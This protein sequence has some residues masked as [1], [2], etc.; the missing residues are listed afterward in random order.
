MDDRGPDR[1]HSLLWIGAVLMVT[2][3]VYSPALM[4]GFITDDRT[5]LASVP[6]WSVA[7]I[8]RFFAHHY[9]AF[10]TTSDNVTATY[11]RPILLLF[12]FVSYR[13]L[14]ASV[15]AWHALAILLHLVVTYLVYRMALAL[16]ADEV[17]ALSSALLFGLHPVHAEVVSW[18]SGISESL[19]AALIIAAFLC[20]TR[21]R[22]LAALSLYCLALL[23][24]ET[25][26]MFPV[27]L[28][29]FA[30]QS[31]RLTKAVRSISPFL[32]VTVAYLVVRHVVLGGVMNSL[33]ATPVHVLLLT[34]PSLALFYVQHFVWPVHLSY[35]YPLN[36][37][38]ALT[39]KILMA[40][41]MVACVFFVSFR[42]ARFATCWAALFL[43]PVFYVSGL[44]NLGIVHDRYLYLP[45]A[46]LCIVCGIAFGRLFAS[47]RRFAVA[48]GAIVMA[49]LASLTVAE[50]RPW[51][52]ETALFRR[53]LELS[54]DDRRATVPLALALA[55]DGDCTEA[56]PLAE[57]ALSGGEDATLRVALGTCYISQ[58][59]LAEADDQFQRAIALKP[60]FVTARLML[61][62][63]RVSEQRFPDA[64][65][66]LNAIAAA[67]GTQWPGF[68]LIRGRVLESRQD[69]TGA[70]AEFRAELAVNP[71]SEQ[72][73]NHL[74]SLER[75]EGQQ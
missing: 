65:D 15:L 34:C 66:Q 57:R 31:D 4:F 73:Q 72:A 23:T 61:A 5:L 1:T 50:C 70:K 71:G 30:M 45:S 35:I 14:G 43:L 41:L 18:V 56:E 51:R 16:A 7:S 54:P 42:T 29:V 37:Q 55:R 46:G 12:D 17:V 6:V 59:R 20:W 11:Y 36:L 28:L 62:L 40:T 26:V 13:A 74:D 58:S 75:R 67:H 32:L 52:D 24:K 60:H 69:W 8:P 49:L 44:T 63:I 33:M 10:I 38:S 39:V 53:V 2:A 27:V 48:A 22:S 21:R 9:W 3:A 64:D 19:T 68:H 25:A 47:N